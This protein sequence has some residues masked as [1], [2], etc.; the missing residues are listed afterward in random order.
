[1]FR[2]GTCVSDLSFG[3]LNLDI[4]VRGNFRLVIVALFFDADSSMAFS[5]HL[6]GGNLGL[7]W[8]YFNFRNLFRV[9]GFVGGWV[10]GRVGG[11]PDPRHFLQ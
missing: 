2:L 9:G 6:S 5:P 1:M 4:F 7:A 3:D 11:N 8:N 10:G